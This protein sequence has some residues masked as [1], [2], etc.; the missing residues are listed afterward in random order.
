MPLTE[1]SALPRRDDRMIMRRCADGWA[2]VDT[3]RRTMLMLNPSARLI[4]EM[5]DGNHTLAQVVC[6]LSGEFDVDERVLEKDVRQFI[7]ELRKRE[8]IVG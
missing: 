2:L 3:Y 4:W 6:R 5:L 7:G 1:K 8:M